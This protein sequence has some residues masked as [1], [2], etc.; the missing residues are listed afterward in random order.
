MYLAAGK[1]KVAWEY[2]NSF[3]SYSHGYFTKL[4]KTEEKMQVWC[5]LH[6]Q[7]WLLGRYA[8]PQPRLAYSFIIWSKTKRNKMCVALKGQKVQKR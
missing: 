4:T 3:H 1:V 5:M 2:G 8:P 7:A 6:G